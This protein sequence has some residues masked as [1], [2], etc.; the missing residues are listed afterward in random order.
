MLIMFILDLL[1]KVISIFSVEKKIDSHNHGTFKDH[2]NN[3]F[4]NPKSTASDYARL[5]VDYP[6]FSIQFKNEWNKIDEAYREPTLA[7][8]ITV[9]TALCIGDQEVAC[10]AFKKAAKAHAI[11]KNIEQSE[12][13]I[14]A[15]KQ[16]IDNPIAVKNLAAMM[17]G[18]CIGWSKFVEYDVTGNLINFK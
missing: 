15:A 13:M 7:L 14:F 11:A 18:E 10:Q 16:V 8:H 12:V 6:D 1:N 9:Y 2:V 3:V 5:A 17:I 4:L